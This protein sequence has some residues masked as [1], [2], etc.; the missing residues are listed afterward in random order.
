MKNSAQCDSGGAAVPIF[1]ANLLDEALKDLQKFKE[2]KIKKNLLLIDSA[3]D[4]VDYIG[5][6]LIVRHN[7]PIHQKIKETIN[8]MK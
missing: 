3:L 5:Q 1:N 6:A 2:E 7:G 4:G 8:L